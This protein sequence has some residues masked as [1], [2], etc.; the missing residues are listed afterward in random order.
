MFSLSYS[1]L[2]APIIIQ[3]NK[4]YKNAFQNYPTDRVSSFCKII[5]RK[6]LS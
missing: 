3:T 4:I 2:P 6:E 5:L 1:M